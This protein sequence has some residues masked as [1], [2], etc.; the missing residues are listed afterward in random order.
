MSKRAVQFFGCMVLIAVLTAVFSGC[1]SHQQPSNDL[2]PGRM[3]EVILTVEWQKT[4][5]IPP[6][7]TKVDVTIVGDGLAD[8]VRDSIPR[9]EG[10]NSVTKTYQVPVGYKRL[11]AEAKDVNNRALASGTGETYL[12]EAQRSSVTIEMTAIT[13]KTVQLHVSRNGQPSLPELVAFQDG[14]GAWQ[15]VQGGN[16]E[17]RMEVADPNGRYGL[18]VVYKTME[19]GPPAVCV[20]ILHATVAELPEVYLDAGTPPLG[21]PVTVSGTVSDSLGGIEAFV[22]LRDAETGVY[23]AWSRQYTVQVEPGTHDLAASLFTA[24]SGSRAERI[25]L[26]RGQNIVGDTTLDIDFDSAEAF[27][28]EVHTITPQGISN[29]EYGNIHVLFHTKGGTSL[30]IAQQ[31]EIVPD[32]FQF[33]AVPAA[34]QVDGDIH[35]VTLTAVSGQ[36]ERTVA[37]FFKAPTDLTLVLPAPFGN[38]TVNPT[39]TTPYLRPTAAWEPYQGAM[40]YSI[41][42]SSEIV[43][44]ARRTRQGPLST[45][46]TVYLSSGWL[47][48]GSTYTLPDLSGVTGWNDEWPLNSAD[49]L[50]W[51]VGASATNMTLPDV[52]NREVFAVDGLEVRTAARTSGDD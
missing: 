21:N 35:E 27:A 40:Y 44:G 14:D 50:W 33:A 49:M 10:Q 7:T 13:A 22:A 32:R 46:W 34:K 47:G 8:P 28:P 25:F 38:V 2:R 26:R 45:V 5:V 42:Y 24:S 17:Y 18:A 43:A 20:T 52:I 19:E 15:A 9:P 12:Q 31:M 4:R 37:H 3:A 30:T 51:M 1:G 16:G 39:P 23:T 11:T 36:G 29:G 48:G 6:E 41:Q